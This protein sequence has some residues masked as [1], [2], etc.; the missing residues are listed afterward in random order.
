MIR[1]PKGLNHNRR[2]FDKGGSGEVESQLAALAV[3]CHG[4]VMKSARRRELSKQRE[5]IKSSKRPLS[6]G[7]SQTNC[8]DK[9][10]WWRHTEPTNA[11]MICFS[12]AVQ[13]L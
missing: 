13:L 9:D 7:Q 10:A 12:A 11:V 3:G 5:T 8:R 6:S 2:Q 1:T 4:G